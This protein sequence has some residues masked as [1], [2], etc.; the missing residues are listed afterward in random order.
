M[1]YKN[2]HVEQYISTKQIFEALQTLKQL[3]NKYYQFVPE[4]DE[5]RRR[6]KENDPNG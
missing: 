4:L 6:C 3:G 1:V 5:Y 2:T